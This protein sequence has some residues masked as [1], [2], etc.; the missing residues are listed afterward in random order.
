MT[1]IR[2]SCGAATLILQIDVAAPQLHH[3]VFAFPGLA[4]GLPSSAAP[5]PIAS[6]AAS[7][8]NRRLRVHGRR[9][10]SASFRIIVALHDFHSAGFARKPK[11]MATKNAK[12][13]KTFHW[14][15]VAADSF[16]SALLLVHLCVFCGNPSV[17]QPANNHPRFPPRSA[18]NRWRIS[19]STSSG[20]AVV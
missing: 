3:R 17:V 8:I 9:A 18:V 6:S 5:Q 1:V 19:S 20:V 15:V 13:R 12:R 4:P 2:K 10:E 14:F 16:R 11:R 7:T